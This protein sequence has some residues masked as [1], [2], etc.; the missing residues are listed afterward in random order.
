MDIQVSGDT[1]NE[2]GYDFWTNA[3][4]A[5]WKSGAGT[6]PCP[7]TEGDGKGFVIASNHTDLEDGT[8]GPAPSLLM[9]PQNKYN[10]YI[11]GFYPTYYRPA[12]G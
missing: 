11:Q 6:L 1:P 9:S 2:F 12:R 5:E 4:A 10:G 7:G 8:K 3:C